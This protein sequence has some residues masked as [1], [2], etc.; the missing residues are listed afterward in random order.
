MDTA[1]CSWNRTRVQETFAKDRPT[2]DTLTKLAKLVAQKQERHSQ[3]HT[4]PDV[5]PYLCTDCGRDFS[6]IAELLR[7]QQGQHPLRKPHRCLS[8]GKE[9][10]LLSS[11]QLHKCVLDDTVCQLCWGIPQLGATCGACKVPDS[12]GVPDKP[13]YHQNHDNLSYACA[14][15]GKG[16]SHKQAL[17]HHQQADCSKS[18]SRT[19][20]E[21]NRLANSPSPNSPPSD[22]SPPGSPTSDS[23]HSR[24]PTSDSPHS[25]SPTR[26][27]NR[28]LSPGGSIQ[29]LLCF[30]S[31]RSGAGLTCHQRLSHQTE[32]RKSR[33]LPPIAVNGQIP[34]QAKG[35]SKQISQLLSC[36]TCD[37]TFL[38]TAKLY[39]HRQELH[40][41]EKDT[42]RDPRQLI[43]K[44]RKGE[45]FPCTVCGKVFLH[46]LSLKAHTKNHS[47]EPA[48]ELHQV[49]KGA[50]VLKTTEKK[51]TKRP[52]SILAQKTVGQLVGA[53][54]GRS[55]KAPAI[56]EEGEYPCPSC[57][58]VFSRQSALKVHE[59]LHQPLGPMRHCSVCSQ[60]MGLSKKPG[61]K[62][63]KAY[64]CVP[65]L[66]AFLTLD[67]FLQHCQDHLVIS[68]NELDDADS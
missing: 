58:E 1:P 45:T 12:Q 8:C 52:K 14:P 21:V 60:C 34:S 63:R 29:C 31:F 37:M 7:H 30:K 18:A 25:R 6:D 22:S 66:K 53:V 67:A 13:I 3:N 64:H 38:S 51:T 55:K 56:E 61:A 62:V 32:W 57:A 9:F 2:S 54:R 49:G 39:M 24:S 50:K 33:G 40:S 42:K 17:L 65:C 59:E 47:K 16:F 36:R 43:S 10:S 5:P 15:C 26:N 41:R 46:H 44:R 4:V 23:P 35:K 11:L 20:K 19:A 68:G 48:S 27:T 28:G